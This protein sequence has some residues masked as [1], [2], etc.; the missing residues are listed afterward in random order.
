MMIRLAHLSDI[1]VRCYKRHQEFRDHFEN[2][3]ESLKSQAPDI[4]TIT[5]D[6]VHQKSF[7]SAELIQ[8]M[9]DFFRS[10]AD[11]AV[12]VIIPGNHDLVMANLSRLDSLSPIVNALNHPNIHYYKY[13]GVYDLDI[14][15]YPISFIHFACFQD[16]KTWP[17]RKDINEE[18]INIGL[19]HGFVMN[20]ILQNGMQIYENAHKV[21][22]FFDIVDYLQL[23]DIHKMQFIGDEEYK[24]VEINEEDV[25]N[26]LND[27]WQFC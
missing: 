26:Y 4:I 1:Q 5:G 27:G 2:L 17:T 7:I 25:Q 19:Y 12:L 9:N 16:E 15:G 21:K 23:G 14:K 20:A 13:S 3:Y 6:L 8:M 22:D 10:L 11:I 24:Y 18:R